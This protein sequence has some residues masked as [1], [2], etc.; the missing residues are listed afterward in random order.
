MSS[1]SNKIA[2]VTGASSGLG[3]DFARQL[4]REGA[5]LVLVARRKPLL[6]KIMSEIQALS[7]VKIYLIPMDLTE[8]GALDKLEAE[9]S[10]LGLQVDCLI[11]NAGY[12][13]FGE[14]L[15]L[16][17]EKQLN[18]ID[19]DIRILVELSH[20]FGLK[21]KQRGSGYI[22]HVASVGAYQATPG[23]SVYCAAKAFVLSFG[24]SMNFELKKYGV[25]VA[26][27]CPGITETEFLQVSGQ[28]LTPYQQRMMMKSSDV[29]HLG[30][31]AML[32]G[33]AILTPG[34]GNKLISFFNRFMPRSL[35][36]S[37]AHQAMR[38]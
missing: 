16:N 1:L 37:L 5:H 35:Q 21:M 23:Y 7:P 32:Q 6:E 20:R 27:L 3:A 26:T 38:N 36:R 2:L 12:G 8:P 19:L 34:F 30:I 13:L 28:R 24:E 9:I 14:F 29:V 4:A 11:N 22:L 18:M 31:Q 25:K 33:R 17:L 15:D 10:K